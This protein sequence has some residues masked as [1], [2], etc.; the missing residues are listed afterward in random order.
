MSFVVNGKQY[1]Y[2]KRLGLGSN[3]SVH[4]VH[5]EKTNKFA[6]KIPVFYHSDELEPEP[7]HI[8]RYDVTVDRF[9]SSNSS[10]SIVDEIVTL[11]KISRY[12]RGECHPNLVCYYDSSI[13]MMTNSWLP[14][15]MQ[16]THNQNI[17]I[18]VEE[19]INGI[20][21]EGTNLSQQ[22]LSKFIPDMLSALSVLDIIGIQYLELHPNNIMYDG[23]NYII[24]DLGET[25]KYDTRTQEDQSREHAVY[26]AE[27]IYITYHGG[28][29]FDSK[30]YN[31]V[32]TMDSDDT[33]DS[34]IKQI[35]TQYPTIP[36]AI[37]MF[38]RHF[39]DLQVQ[40]TLIDTIDTY[41]NGTVVQSNSTYH[42]TH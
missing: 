3:G 11:Q 27:L 29:S 31:D 21:L 42:I 10:E 19:Y 37:I 18:I 28:F 5:D 33:Y 40:I 22:Q 25:T 38:S 14:G 41:Q 12:L 17:P 35:I 24:I 34:V 13:S 9:H 6:V 15:P 7:E 8:K 32:I 23:H 1:F 4:L 26:L 16:N 30:A 39:P 2:I 20:T 36:E